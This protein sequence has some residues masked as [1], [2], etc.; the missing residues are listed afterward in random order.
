[1]TCPKCKGIEVVRPEAGS[2][3]MLNADN[4]GYIKCDMCDGTGSVPRDAASR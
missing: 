4:M 1:M 3:Q 2:P